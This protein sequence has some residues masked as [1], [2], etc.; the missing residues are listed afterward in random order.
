MWALLKK[1]H[2]YGDRNTSTGIG[3]E[4]GVLVGRVVGYWD[5]PPTNTPIQSLC[6]YDTF[7][8]AWL[9]VH[10]IYS[11]STGETGPQEESQELPAEEQGEEQPAT[12]Q[13]S[14]SS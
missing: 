3:L 6:L 8:M 12:Q 2:S 14:H 9:L 1:I 5:S 7:C 11:H 10:F 4:I 13:G